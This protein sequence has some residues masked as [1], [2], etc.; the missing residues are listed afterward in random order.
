MEKE[1]LKKWIESYKSYF[2]S[3][4]NH[5]PEKEWEYV[6]VERY[7]LKILH[8]SYHSL[9]E[10]EWP[11]FVSNL[12]SDLEKLTYEHVVVMMSKDDWRWKMAGSWFAGLKRYSQFKKEIGE[13]LQQNSFSFTNQTY[14]FA[15]ACFG[16]DESIKYLES[17]L[18]QF[19]KNFHS[20]KKNFQDW[21]LYA[22]EWI[23]LRKET[24]VAKNFSHL[25]Q[26]HLDKK[27]IDKGRNLFSHHV[28]LDQ[29]IQNK[30]NAKEN[31]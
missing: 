2:H 26:E 5:S 10:Q 15:L 17:C 4:T 25:M 6:L 18:D 24:S 13:S 27:E 1:F 28:D 9:T 3:S 20:S 8:S 19:F 11:L 12:Y 16:D 31:Q 29:V 7:S 23:D 14:S 22:L 21:A 30:I